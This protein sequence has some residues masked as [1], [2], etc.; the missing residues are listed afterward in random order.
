MSAEA[1]EIELVR[2][3]RTA[4][5]DGRL[6]DV[7]IDMATDVR[8]QLGVGLLAMGLELAPG[9]QPA[10]RAAV[11]AWLVGVVDRGP[12]GDGFDELAAGAALLYALTS[13]AGTWSC[14]RLPGGIWIVEH[15]PPGVDEPSSFRVEKRGGRWRL[16]AI[17]A[18][19]F[20]ARGLRRQSVEWRAG[21]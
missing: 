12:G 13:D 9:F 5:V 2:R 19:P 7:W 3:W 17:G 11:L 21:V 16:A 20:D 15:R 4:V 14:R 1:E 18:E 6:A 10:D 8:L